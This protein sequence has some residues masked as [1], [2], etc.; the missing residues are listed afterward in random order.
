MNHNNTMESLLDIIQKN[1]K[2]KLLYSELSSFRNFSFQK[3]LR[4]KYENTPHPLKLNYTL[5]LCIFL[6]I[7]DVEI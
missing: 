4:K 6:S 3:V 5:I 1:Y 2:K 7:S